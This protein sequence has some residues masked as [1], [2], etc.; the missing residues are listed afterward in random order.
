MCFDNASRCDWHAVN[1]CCMELFLMSVAQSPGTLAEH[2]K[3]HGVASSWGSLPV[4]CKFFNTSSETISICGTQVPQTVAATLR[5]YCL[6][7]GS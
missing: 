1:V 3:H 4:Q 2:Q 5:I 7:S 6:S